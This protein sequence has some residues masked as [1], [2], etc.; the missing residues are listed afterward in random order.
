M[1]QHPT[2]D[3]TDFPPQPCAESES[4]A[5][6]GLRL[7]AAAPIVSHGNAYTGTAVNRGGAETAPG[8]LAAI[9]DDC[10]RP[11]RSYVQ[12]IRMAILN[13]PGH[14]LTV[15]QIYKRIGRNLEFDKR[16][17][18]GWRNTIRHTLSLH[19]N[20]V[21]LERPKGDP[22]KG[23]Y[24][25]VAHGGGPGSSDGAPQGAPQGAPDI[26]REAIGSLP[27]GEWLDAPL[28][29]SEE[30]RLSS[31]AEH[32]IARL[33]KKKN[34]TI[35]S[36]ITPR[37]S[38]VR[39][40][41]TMS[42]RRVAAT[43]RGPVVSRVRAKTAKLPPSASPSTSPAR[44]YRDVSVFLAWPIGSLG[45]PK[46]Q[47]DGAATSCGHFEDT[48]EDWRFGQLCQSEWMSRAQRAAT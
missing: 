14:K 16:Q 29:L 4:D 22:G 1:P 35:G 17:G 38:A 43:T 3:D 32:E 44:C 26:P 31:R 2:S 24:W 9:T 42:P 13:S 48:F 41:M 12:L 20:F 23:H 34:L 10:P 39:S 45:G 27:G 7:S 6:G 33:R 40:A 11:R 5:N 25:A 28:D 36:S 46:V 18:G 19:K 21:K 30:N 47:D 8:A 37:S 15:D